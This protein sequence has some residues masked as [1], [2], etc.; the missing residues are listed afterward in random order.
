MFLNE[1]AD[2]VHQVRLSQTDAAVEE[3]RVIRHARLF[4]D[5]QRGGMCKPI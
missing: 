2:G 4:G 1:M 5:G 3:Q